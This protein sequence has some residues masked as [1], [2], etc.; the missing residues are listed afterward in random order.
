MTVLFRNLRAYGYRAYNP[1]N[2]CPTHH[3]TC[4]VSRRH[5]N[6]CSGVGDFRLLCVY[7]FTTSASYVAI[8]L[9]WIADEANEASITQMITRSIP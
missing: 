4:S 1:C 5:S 9:E 6:V 8:P 2:P 3:L 7:I